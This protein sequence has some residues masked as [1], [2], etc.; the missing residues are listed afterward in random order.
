V[1][2]RHQPG[3]CAP[4]S[5]TS[6]WRAG[7]APANRERL[8]EAQPTKTY[9]RAYSRSITGGPTQ[10]YHLHPPSPIPYSPAVRLGILMCSRCLF[11][12]MVALTPFLLQLFRSPHCITSSFA[13]G[14]TVS[15]WH[16][17]RLGKVPDLLSQRVQCG[18][19]KF[20]VLWRTGR[21]FMRFLPVH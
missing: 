8:K 12:E 9:S 16:C 21:N 15:T 18:S 4:Q 7:P 20:V 10:P 6:T 5:T 3:T 14:N 2:A 13:S 1:S 11:W 17:V 19:Q